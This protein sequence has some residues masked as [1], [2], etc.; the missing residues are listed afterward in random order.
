MIN[1]GRLS[2][3]R[4]LIANE[5]PSISFHPASIS[6]VYHLYSLTG[7][8]QSAQKSLISA[9]EGLCG[10]GSSVSDSEKFAAMMEIARLQRSLGN[11]EEASKVYQAILSNCE[12]E[13][14]QRLTVIA[15]LVEA[16][17]HTE[18]NGEKYMRSLSQVNNINK[19]I[20]SI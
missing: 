18:E 9:V 13:T 1:R 15:K 5:L 8:S 19:C 17:S 14:A 16:L 6:S 3:A 11:C 20:H 7:D 4:E 2:E 12:L 10:Q